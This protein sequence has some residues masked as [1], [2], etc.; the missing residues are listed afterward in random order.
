MS[1][2]ASCGVLEIRR[3]FSKS[4]SFITCQARVLLCFLCMAQPQLRHAWAARRRV[5]P[6]ATAP[7]PKQARL[8]PCGSLPGR[9][10]RAAPWL[11][12]QALQTA[13]RALP[14]EPAV[15]TR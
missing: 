3:Y 13:R 1:C 11:A 15:S 4:V 12:A 7:S 8:R 5:D 2:S 10:C 14:A 9:P 6:T